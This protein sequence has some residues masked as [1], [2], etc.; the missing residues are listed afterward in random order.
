MERR[1]LVVACVFFVA[2]AALVVAIASTNSNLFRG[3]FN[4]NLTQVKST[5]CL[6]YGLC[7]FSLFKRFPFC[8]N[9]FSLSGIYLFIFMA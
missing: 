6:R 1:L 9:I 5:H 8:V 3:K 2:C 7:A 4:H